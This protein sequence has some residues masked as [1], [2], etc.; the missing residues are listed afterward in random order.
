[1]KW[2]KI[3]IEI[4]KQHVSTHTDQQIADILTNKQKKRISLSAVRKQR[5]RLG[6]RK[7]AGRGICKVI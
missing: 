4:L 3:E 1:M 6:I 2:T 5:Q 7:A